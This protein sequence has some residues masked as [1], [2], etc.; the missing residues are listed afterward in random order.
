MAAVVATDAPGCFGKLPG[1]GDF[2]RTP[3]QHALMLTL[4]RWAGGSIELLARLDRI[5]GATFT[6]NQSTPCHGPQ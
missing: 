5:A 3:D 2:V 1:R 4:D 6:A